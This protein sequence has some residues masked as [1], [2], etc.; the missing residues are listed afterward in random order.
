MKKKKKKRIK[1][2]CNIMLKR[3]NIL[4]TITSLFQVH[5]KLKACRNSKLNFSSCCF[6]AN[7]SLVK[8]AW[9]HALVFCE[10][11]ILYF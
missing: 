5:E 6:I 11:D 4:P 2:I 3:H 1:D 10:H 7:D 9:L 8:T